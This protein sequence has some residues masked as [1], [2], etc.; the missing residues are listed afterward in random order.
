MRNWTDLELESLYEIAS[1]KLGWLSRL[2]E[3]MKVSD[4]DIPYLRW[5]D[6]LECETRKKLKAWDEEIET[7]GGKEIYFEENEAKQFVM[8]TKK[9]NELE[10]QIDDDLLNRMVFVRYKLKYALMKKIE[11]EVFEKFTIEQLE[12]ARKYPLFKLMG[13]PHKKNILCPFHKEKSPSFS[14]GI[15]GFCF[16]CKSY[17]DSIGY[18]MSN[19]SLTFSEAVTILGNR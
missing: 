7:Y 17:I 18:L 8:L 6:D 11:P 1:G 4:E 15:W 13:F 19:R 12:K 5:L 14:V 9:M 10:G 16:T 3:N 2:Q